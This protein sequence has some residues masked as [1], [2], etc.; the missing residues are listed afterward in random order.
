[1]AVGE[2]KNGGK[3]GL[4]AARVE[5][6]AIS[7]NQCAILCSSW[8]CTGRLPLTSRDPTGSHARFA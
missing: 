3:I 2:C 7:V 1:M 4:K 5:Q 6:N 8:S